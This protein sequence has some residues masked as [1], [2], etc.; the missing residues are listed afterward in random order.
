MATHFC[1]DRELDFIFLVQ[2]I[3]DLDLERIFTVII[4]IIIAQI[5]RLGSVIAAPIV[6]GIESVLKKTKEK[7]VTVSLSLQPFLLIVRGH[8]RP[9]F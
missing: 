2:R 3:G 1:L 4:G 5:D 8:L 7:A 9:S 6:R